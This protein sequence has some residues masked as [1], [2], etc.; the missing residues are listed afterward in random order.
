MIQRLLGGLDKIIY[1]MLPTLRSI[2]KVK[3]A[4]VQYCLSY[5]ITGDIQLFL[6]VPGILQIL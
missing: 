2:L 6:E 3:R 1:S 5:Q 4:R